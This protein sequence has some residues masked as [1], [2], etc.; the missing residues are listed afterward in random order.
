MAEVDQNGKAVF[1]NVPIGVNTIEIPAFKDYI[2]KTHEAKMIVPIDGSL[3]ND[4]SEQ[5]KEFKTYVEI[6][7]TGLVVTKVTL[8]F[9]ESWTD[10][11]DFKRME[12][13]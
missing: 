2:A 3:V 12:R 1:E 6:S 5:P 9:P 11:S 4:G 13:L 8:N 7:K 10:D